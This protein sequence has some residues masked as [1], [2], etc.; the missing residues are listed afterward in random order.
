MV[1]VRIAYINLRGRP[2]RAERFLTHNAAELDASA[3]PW[4]RVDGIDG[5]Q[6]ASSTANELVAGGIIAANGLQDGYAPHTWGHLGCASSHRSLWEEAARSAEDEVLVILEDDAQVCPQFGIRLR[7]VLKAAEHRGPWDVVH[8]GFNTDAPLTIQ[9]ECPRMDVQLI[10]QENGLPIGLG[11]PF[12][13][14]WPQKPY[15]GETLLARVLEFHGLCGYAVSAPGARRLL[16]VCLPM[17]ATSIDGTM[18]RK[19]REGELQALI[20]IPPIVLSD[21]DHADSNTVSSASSRYN[22]AVR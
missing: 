22:E 7:H 18:S 10:C 19:L 3:I 17:S 13:V 1:H 12:A 20:A 15:E 8:L 9:L 2:D 21:N 16:E 6:L 11:A 14:D 4:R 5:S